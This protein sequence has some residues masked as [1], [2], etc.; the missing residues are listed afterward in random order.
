M[1]LFILIVFFPKVYMQNVLLFQPHLI[2][3]SGNFAL[4]MKA[5]RQAFNVSST[6]DDGSSFTSQCVSGSYFSDSPFLITV[7]YSQ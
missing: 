7:D 1:F 5:L 3:D 2:R 4:K 6:T